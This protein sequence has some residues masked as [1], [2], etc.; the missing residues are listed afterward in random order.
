MSLIR[1][2]MK[3]ALMKTFIL[4]RKNIKMLRSRVDPPWSKLGCQRG[5]EDLRMRDS[6]RY[7]IRLIS[8][9]H[10]E[11][12]VQLCNGVPNYPRNM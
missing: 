12:S 7:E 2:K 1:Q 6:R 9:E 10:Q 11:F 8:W 5:L 3:L 4:M